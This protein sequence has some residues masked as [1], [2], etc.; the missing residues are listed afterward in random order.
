MSNATYN[1]LWHDTEC[2]L[3]EVIQTDSILQ[4]V[5]PQRDRQKVHKNVSDLYVR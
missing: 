1:E 4:N 2:A 5:K 3:E